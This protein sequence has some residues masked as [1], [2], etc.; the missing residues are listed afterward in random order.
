MS[1]NL[2]I[3]KQEPEI[4][5]LLARL[6]GLILEQGLHI[7]EGF[8]YKVPFYKYLGWLCYLS[9]SKGQLYVG[10]CEG[11]RL[12]N[13]YGLLEAEG[14]SHVFRFYINDLAD[15]Q[16]KEEALRETLQEAMLVNELRLAARKKKKRT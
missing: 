6:R 5:A 2:Y 12:S 4:Q 7:E 11:H 16:A 9:Y 13:T 15:L 8:S 14:R 3:E 10:F 1:V